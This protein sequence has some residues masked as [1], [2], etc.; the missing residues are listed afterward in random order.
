M[1]SLHPTKK[2]MK[3]QQYD[4]RDNAL[5][6]NEIPIPSPRAHELLVKVACASLCHSDVMLF[7]PND[8]GL[9][10]GSNPCVTIG[11]EGSGF[12][13]ASGS[14]D[15]GFKAGDKVGFLCAVDCCFDC[16][17]CRNVHNS[18]CVTGNTKMQGFTV[19]GYFQEYVC[20]DA[21]AAM[22][23]PEGL[24]VYKAAPL[25]CAGVTAFHGVED[26]HLE[27]GKWM[28]VVGC[29]GLGHLGIMYAKA[30]G[31]KVIGLDIAPQALDAAKESG[32]D[33]VFNTMTDKDWQKKII[34]LTDG[35]VDAAVNFTAS[36]KSYD[37]APAII[38]PGSGILMV[39]GIP[40]KPIE[41]NA[42]DI[43]LGRYRVLGSNNGTCYNMRSCIEFSAKHNINAHLTHYKLEEVPKMIELMNSHKAQGRMGVRFD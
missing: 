35:G 8:Q 15:L 26:C 39:V 32:A 41:L 24:D 30:M 7:E 42:L 10:L 23:L 43:A 29:G 6:L 25:F 1:G 11:H 38:R 40:Q 36:K 5:H 22:V 21:R 17:A 3:A 28:A 18:W 37:D 19:D 12:V 31:L 4:A 2:T 9:I 27:E 14:A 34:E 16:Y 33:H 20:V 13:V